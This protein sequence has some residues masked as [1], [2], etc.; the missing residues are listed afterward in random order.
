[1]NE[2]LK[3]VSGEER[4]RAEY[5][6]A[7]DLISWHALPF[8]AHTELFTPELLDYAIG[9]SKGLDERYSKRTIAAKATDVP[10]MTKPRKNSFRNTSAIRSCCRIREKRFRTT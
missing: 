6:I 9:I 8:T 5:A 3:C 10:G 1:M 4:K 7:N 2:Y